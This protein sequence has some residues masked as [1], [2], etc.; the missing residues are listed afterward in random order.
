MTFSDI[1]AGS[2]V[3]VT[4]VGTYL[5][6]RRGR[7]GDDALAL[8][9]AADRRSKETETNLKTQTDIIDNLQEEVGRYRVELNAKADELGRRH[10]ELE[11]ARNTIK[12]MREELG[13]ATAGL[14]AAG[15]IIRSLEATV[16]VLQTEVASLRRLVQDHEATIAGHERTINQLRHAHDEAGATDL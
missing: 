11:D 13:E 1:A 8:S 14:S 16:D 9:Q 10:V 5:V 3:T 6:Y 2:A 15:V 4:A 12:A 7:K